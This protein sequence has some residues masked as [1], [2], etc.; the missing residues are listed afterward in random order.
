PSGAVLAGDIDPD[1]AA[2]LPPGVMLSP[3]VPDARAVAM[4]A[5]RR[6]V[7]ARPPAPLYVRSPDARPA[8]HPPWA[9]P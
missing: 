4:L 3:A 5:A 7:P 9:A 1:L 8:R 6:D 2:A